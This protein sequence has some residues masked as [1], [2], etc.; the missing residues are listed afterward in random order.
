MRKSAQGE[1]QGRFILRVATVLAYTHD[2]KIPIYAAVFDVLTRTF[3]ETALE[4]R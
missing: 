4:L 1:E 2:L 3:I